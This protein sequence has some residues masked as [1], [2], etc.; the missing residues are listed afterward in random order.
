MLDN[1]T[2]PSSKFRTKEWIEIN[3]DKLRKYD[4]CGGKSKVATT[5]LILIRLDHLRV[6]FFWRGGGRGGVNFPLPPL[7]YFRKNY[8]ISI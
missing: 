3:H 1:I 2:N 5:M 7:S 8:L 4:T 6:L